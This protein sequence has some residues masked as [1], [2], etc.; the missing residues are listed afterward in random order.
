MAFSAGWEPLALPGI[1]GEMGKIKPLVPLLFTHPKSL[2]KLTSINFQ[3]PRQTRNKKPLTK[4][5]PS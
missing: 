1:I 2:S 4:V 3:K 5:K